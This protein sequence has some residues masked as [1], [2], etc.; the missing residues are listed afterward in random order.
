[1]IFSKFKIVPVVQLAAHAKSST[2]YGRKVVRSYV[3]ITKFF[4]LDGLL[5]FRIIMGLRWIQINS[6]RKALHASERHIGEFCPMQ[7]NLN[8]V[9][10]LSSWKMFVKRCSIRSAISSSSAHYSAFALASPYD[11]LRTETSTFISNSRAPA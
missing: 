6:N 8:S 10:L 4:G 9:Q 1:M 7:N 2:S 11:S 3:R 5:L